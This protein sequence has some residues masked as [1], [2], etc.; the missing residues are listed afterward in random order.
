MVSKTI[1]TII[2]PVA[3]ISVGLGFL[4]SAMA[5]DCNIDSCTLVAVDG[6]TYKLTGDAFS[7]YQDLTLRGMSLESMRLQSQY[8]DNGEPFLINISGPSAEVDKLVSRYIVNK[9]SEQELPLINGK[10][11][12]G[13]TVKNNLLGFL[14]V[15]DASE[16]RSKSVDVRPVSSY[17]MGE[18][19]IFREFLT[20]GQKQEIANDLE[21][22]KQNEIRKIIVEKQGVSMIGQQE[23]K[24]ELK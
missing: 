1:L 17:D 18:G 22:F 24:A 4:F 8:L 3:A 13:T 2:I 9:T 23:K 10:S 7:S 14:S 16:L 12:F 20:T 21:V 6:K 11:V 19:R 5:Q 15:S